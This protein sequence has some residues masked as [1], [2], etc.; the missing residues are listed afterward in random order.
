MST[1]LVFLLGMITQYAMFRQRHQEEIAIVEKTRQVEIN[2]VYALLV[3]VEKSYKEDITKF[4]ETLHELQQLNDSLRVKYK[5][6][7]NLT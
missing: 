7:T 6:T 4:K 2:N 3:E 1:F 5:N